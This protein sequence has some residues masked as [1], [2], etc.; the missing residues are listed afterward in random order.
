MLFRGKN[1]GNVLEKESKAGRKCQCSV[2]TL[3]SCCMC[4]HVHPLH[5]PAFVCT[6]IT[7]VCYAEFKQLEISENQYQYHTIIIGILN[8]DSVTLKDLEMPLGSSRLY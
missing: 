2:Y 6:Y 8:D 3:F 7:N 4:T 5:I 1:G